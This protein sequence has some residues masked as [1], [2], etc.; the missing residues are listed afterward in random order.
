M[1]LPSRLLEQPADVTG[2]K[3]EKH[4]LVVMDKVH[5]RNIYLNHFKLMK[6]NINQQSHS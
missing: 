2:P 1:E 6:N 3:I 5:M 4:M